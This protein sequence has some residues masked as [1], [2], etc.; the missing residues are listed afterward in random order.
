MSENPNPVVCGSC[1]TENPPGAEYCA[2]CGAAFTT[3]AELAE[4]APDDV[5]SPDPGV[6]SANATD[7][8]ENPFPTD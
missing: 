2:E 4:V 5:R 6:D 7:P 1:H 3:A 8:A